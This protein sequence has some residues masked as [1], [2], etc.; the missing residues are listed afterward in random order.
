VKPVR[1]IDLSSVPFYGED[2]WS[3]TGANPPAATSDDREVYL[4]GRNLILLTH[5]A[6]FAA[7]QGIGEIAVGSLKGNPFPDATEEF[8]DAFST[9]ATLGLAR[10][11]RVSA[12]YRTLSKEELIRRFWY[13]PLEYTFSCLSPVNGNHCGVCNKC[14][15]RFRAFES[16]GL[17]DPTEYVRDRPPLRPLEL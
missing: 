11:I 15:E 9:A 2:H 16:A 5:A 6:A 10:G 17:A 7:A 1:E 14:A 13:L 8:F 4:P 12:P 3:V